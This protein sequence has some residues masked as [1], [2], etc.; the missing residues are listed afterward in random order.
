VK[1]SWGT[2]WGLSGY[3]LLARGVPGGDGTCGI[4]LN[5]AYPVLAGGKCDI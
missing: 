2:D 4:L 1:N 5:A 3:A